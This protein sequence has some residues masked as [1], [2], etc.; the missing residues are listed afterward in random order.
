MRNAAGKQGQ[1]QYL[2]LWAGKGV[3]RAR[4]MPAGDLMRRLVAEMHAAG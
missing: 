2:S 1:A 3:A 4:A